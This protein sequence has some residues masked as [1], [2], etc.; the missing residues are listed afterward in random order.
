MANRENDR[1]Q[2][3]FDAKRRYSEVPATRDFLK[4][5]FVMLP[6]ESTAIAAIV[7]SGVVVTLYDPKSKRGGLIHF[8][9]PKP[10]KGQKSTAAFGLPA[11][12]YLTNAMLEFAEKKDLLAGLYGGA[13]PTWATYLQKKTAEKNVDLA[14][15]FMR[16][17]GINI[18]DDD[19]GGQRGRK[20]VYNTENNEIMIYKTD[21]VRRM[22]WYS[23]LHV[24]SARA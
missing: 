19:V 23:H 16:S 12:T 24:G 8:V 22:D 9:M 2:G 3:A 6:F 13:S 5:G 21:L 10:R 14:R 4:P 11:L 20:L 18:A 1:H 15:R 7:A 17:R